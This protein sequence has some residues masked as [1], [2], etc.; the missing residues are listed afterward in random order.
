VQLKL[1]TWNIR[2]CI[3]S[4]GI[5]S[6]ERCAAV[7]TEMD[8]DLVA[9]Q[10]VESRPGHELDAL[11]FLARETGT[12]AVAGVTMVGGDVHYGNAVLTRLPCRAVRHHNLGVPG[13]EP[14][15][16]LDIDLKTDGFFVQVI[17]THLGLSAAERLEQVRRLLPFFQMG[18][19]DLV[20]LTGD[21]NEWRP[22]GRSLRLLRRIFPHTPNRR[23]WPAHAPV[24]SLDRIWVHP[25]GTLRRLATHKSALARVAS[26]HLPVT[27]E[28]EL[29]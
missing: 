24:F 19:R 6:K 12:R 21:L 27:A 11:G 8:A 2:R 3:G 22:W 14:R 9:L 10:E 5:K 29:D 13:R 1:A 17:A 23:S 7:L 18:A 25:F 28:I 20:A 16:A 26:D 15:A 4:D